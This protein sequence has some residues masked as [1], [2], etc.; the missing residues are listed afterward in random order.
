MNI[1]FLSTIASVA[2]DLHC[3]VHRI[4]MILES[5]QIL[6]AALDHLNIPMLS[7]FVF[8]D[9]EAKHLKPYKPTHKHHPSVLW[10]L[11]GRSHFQWLLDMALELC[12]IHAEL[13]SNVHLCEH[14]LKQIDNVSRSLLPEDASPDNWLRRLCD[15][16]IPDK[17]VESCRSKIV[18]KSAP[19][20]CSFG[21]CCIETDGSVDKGDIC[22]DDVV[23]SYTSYYAFKAK[24]K[25][26]MTWKGSQQV[27]KAMKRS[28]GSLLPDKP[29]LTKEEIPKRARVRVE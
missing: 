25:M 20:G 13:R 29:S 18:T 8:K 27:P 22:T 7:F 21:V 11:G 26:A 14:H 2:A 16:G 10:V 17:V 6:Y 3:D 23:Q 9:G 24:C 4:K 15:M 1:F 19:Q 12:R 5:T 28:F